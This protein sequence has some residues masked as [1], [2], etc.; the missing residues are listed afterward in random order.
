MI[1]SHYSLNV[2]IGGQ[3]YCR[4]RLGTWEP[5]ALEKAKAIT[6]AFEAAWAGAKV[7]C[8]LTYVECVGHQVTF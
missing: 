6:R 2:A 4:I 3:H 5:E 7:E 8:A 1:E